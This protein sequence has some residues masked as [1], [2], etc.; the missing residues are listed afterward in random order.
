MINWLIVPH[1]SP[2]YSKKVN[3][4]NEALGNSTEILVVGCEQSF[5]LTIS[6]HRIIAT[7]C[8]AQPRIQFNFHFI[9]GI[10]CFSSIDE[11]SASRKHITNN[12]FGHFRLELVTLI[13]IKIDEFVKLHCIRNCVLFHNHP[14]SFIFLVQCAVDTFW[15]SI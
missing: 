9:G 12:Q 6:I 8:I 7:E 1:C 10:I 13:L 14:Q 2:L 15:Q 4:N 5:C 11:K 3:V